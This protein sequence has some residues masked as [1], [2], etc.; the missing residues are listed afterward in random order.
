MASPKTKTITDPLARKNANYERKT[1]L[2]G[3]IRKY[4]ENGC[5]VSIDWKTA[6]IEE[7]NKEV[8]RLNTS[9]ILKYHSHA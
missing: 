6:S 7:L 9:N 1:Y 2:K 3:R 8:I 5:E 4:L